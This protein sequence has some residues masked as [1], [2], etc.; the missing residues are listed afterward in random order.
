[1]IDAP[2]ITQATAQHTAVIRFTIPRAEIQAVMGPGH[3][4]L[5]AAIAAQGVAPAPDLWE[6]YVAGPESGPDPT[7]W[8]TELNRPLI[9]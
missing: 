6:C 8:S 1:M 7:T 3:A 5:M 4:E 9:R 2:Q